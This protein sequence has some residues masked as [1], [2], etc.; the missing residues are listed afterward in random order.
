MNQQFKMSSKL[1][2]WLRWMEV[3]EAQI[4]HLLGDVEAFRRVRGIVNANPRIQKPHRFYRYL[5]DSYISHAVMGLRR[6]VKPQKD[7]ISLAG[8]LEEII[9]TPKELSFD[10]Y[11]SILTLSLTPPELGIIEDDFKR[12]ADANGTHVCPQMVSND[13][14]NLRKETEAC[15]DYAEKRIAHRDK[16]EPKLVETYEKLE[17]QLDKGLELL[18]KTYVKYHLLFHAE[19]MRTAKPA[20]QGDWKAIFSEPWMRD[21]A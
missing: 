5:F 17:Y 7:S 14:G 3:I 8:L 4:S 11:R 16:R 9:K 13:L 12:H 2:K 10:Y 18:D 1:E 21:V 20:Y 6:Q 19:G 15:E